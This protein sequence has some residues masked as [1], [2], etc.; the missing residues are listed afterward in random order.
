MFRSVLPDVLQFLPNHLTTHTL[1]C[2]SPAIRADMRTDIRLNGSDL[3]MALARASHWERRAKNTHQSV[4]KG[5]RHM[6]DDLEA[7]RRCLPGIAFRF[8]DRQDLTDLIVLNGNLIYHALFSEGPDLFA[9][10]VESEAEEEV[11]EEEGG[12]EI[13]D[14]CGATDLERL[15][16]QLVAYGPRKC[17]LCIRSS[18]V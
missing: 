13:C 15:Y 3:T 1:L 2:C 17:S 12:S 8:G 14:Q 18:Q 11:E 10:V 5:L 6:N 9:E 7:A 4:E 16:Y